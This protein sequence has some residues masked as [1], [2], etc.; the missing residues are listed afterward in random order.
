MGQKIDHILKSQGSREQC[1]LVNVIY[2]LSQNCVIFLHTYQPIS[3]F[4][5]SL[6]PFCVLKGYATKTVQIVGTE[7]II[8][9]ILL[10]PVDI[11]EAQYFKLSANGQEVIEL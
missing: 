1:T 3:I 2:S 8:S 11:R 4:L 6:Y 7:I 10:I 9:V 5:E